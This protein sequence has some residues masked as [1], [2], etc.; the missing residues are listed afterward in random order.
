MRAQM[1]AAGLR[2]NARA[3]RTAALLAKLRFAVG[4]AAFEIEVPVAAMKGV[5]AGA[6]RRVEI[7]AGGGAGGVVERPFGFIRHGA[8]LIDA[9]ARESDAGDVDR[10]TSG[11]FAQFGAG[12]A[13]ARPAFKAGPRPDRRDR[14]VEAP[15][16]QRR[17]SFADKVRESRGGNAIDRRAIRQVD[18][19]AAWRRR[20]STVTGSATMQR[21]SL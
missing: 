10:K 16:C 1:G 21:G 6:E 8:D 7:A 2:R 13:V 18:A 12:E 15:F 4:A 3:L 19:L 20:D 14:G 9:P 17:Q 11:V 5:G